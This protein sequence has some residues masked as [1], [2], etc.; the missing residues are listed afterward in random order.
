MFRAQPVRFV[1][2]L[3]VWAV[4]GLAA[5]AIA[6]KAKPTAEAEFHK[7]WA[8]NAFPATSN[9]PVSNVP[10]SFVYGGRH[11]SELLGA[12]SGFISELFSPCRPEWASF[13][14]QRRW[15]R[16]WSSGAGAT[17]GCESVVRQLFLIVD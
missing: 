9:S 1:F 2:A 6:A 8:W 15:E 13:Y 17:S 14:S 10:F 16:R 11:S 12:S 5:P 3:F 4:T 7:H